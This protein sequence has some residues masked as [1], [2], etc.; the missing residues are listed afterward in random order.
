MAYLIFYFDYTTKLHPVTYPHEVDN[1]RPTLRL[2]VAVALSLSPS[3]PL[4][5]SL[6]LSLSPPKF[7]GCWPKHPMP[8]YLVFEKNCTLKGV[9]S[10]ASEGG[11][12][13]V[14]FRKP[15]VQRPFVWTDLELKLGAAFT[16]RDI[17]ACTQ[18][19]SLRACL[20]Q[21]RNSMLPYAAHL[22]H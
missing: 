6:S 19:I 20:A 9:L 1:D 18:R 12:K 7:V 15:T 16:S 22:R 17:D 10:N 4:S 5:L 2:E 21:G 13:R 14:V 8:I 11:V 3:L